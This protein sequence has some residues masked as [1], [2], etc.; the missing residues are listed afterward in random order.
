MDNI[1]VKI[2]EA[3]LQIKVGFYATIFSLV[4]TFIVMFITT[5]TPELGV[6]TDWT[7]LVDIGLMAILAFGIWKRSRTAT[8]LMFFYFLASKIIQLAAGQFSG[9]ILGVIFLFFFGRAMIA[10]Y[11]Y[12]D[13]IKKGGNQ[14]DVF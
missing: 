1:S 3:K 11:R 12:H 7:Y 9:I 5:S 4:M 14:V 2:E 6:G 10:S 8:T 13:L